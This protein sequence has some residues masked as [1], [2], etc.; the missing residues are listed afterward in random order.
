MCWW[1][2]SGVLVV[3]WWCVGG[4]LV[5]CWWCMCDVC[6]DRIWNAKSDPSLFWK[7][8]TKVYLKGTSICADIVQRACLYMRKVAGAEHTAHIVNSN[9][10]PAGSN[11][12]RP[13][14]ININDNPK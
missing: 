8:V 9:M 2:V 7:D 13:F 10:I 12:R 6:V 4:V 14:R 5:V 3:C 1:C 11:I